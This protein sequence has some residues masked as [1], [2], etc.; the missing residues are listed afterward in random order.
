MGESRIES[1][2]PSAAPLPVR[3]AIAH[4]AGRTGIGFDFLLAQA[5]IE[6][7][8]DPDAKARTSSATGLFQF[9]ESTWLATVRK[10]GAAHGLAPYAAAIG[11]GANG[12][13]V[14][15][16]AMRQQILGLRHDPALAS[17]MAGA[18][19]QDNRAELIPVL[20]REPDAGELYLAHFLGSGGASRF[21][22]ALQSDPSQSAAALFPR[23]AAANRPIF[24]ERDGTAR[25]LSEVMDLMRGKMAQAMD[26][27][28]VSGHPAFAAP[29]QLASAVPAPFLAA[30]NG[31]AG[32]A[33]GFADN[34]PALRPIS[35][36][37][38]QGFTGSPGQAGDHARR[39]Y[40][41]L[42]SFGL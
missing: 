9:I 39:A 34:R 41:T 36:L 27:G 35:E 21:L 8:L 10:H 25:S 42:R 4:G 22:S 31:F 19:A 32:A 12:P 29:G 28:P 17:V 23:P 15:D 24:F 40:A 37:L 1:V 7:G 18:L 30:R 20:G 2:R 13:Y 6:S 11:Q 38:A 14:S 16:P 5:R 3:A 33:S 26:A